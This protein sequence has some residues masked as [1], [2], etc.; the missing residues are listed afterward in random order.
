MVATGYEYG[1]QPV[2]H[3]EVPEDD[4]QDS[5]RQQKLTPRLEMHELFFG[6]TFGEPLDLLV[7][8]LQ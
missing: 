1:A 5:R 8:D 3:A 6:D 2:V 4:L 7:E